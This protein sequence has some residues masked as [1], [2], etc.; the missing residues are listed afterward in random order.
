MGNQRS[1]TNHSTALANK[2]LK[3]ALII[4]LTI[5]TAEI[6][7]GIASNN[8]A[9]LGDAGHMLVDA[10]ALGMS[11]IAIRIGRRPSTSTKTYGYHRV[12]IM[13]ALA[14]GVT[15]ILVSV[16]IF[17]EA[18]QRFSNPPTVNTPLM[19]PLADNRERASRELY[20]GLARIHPVGEV[21]RLLEEL[22]LQ[23]LEHKQQVEFLYAEVAFPQTDGG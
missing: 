3:I 22:A 17:Y 6:V 7:G 16:Y 13:A 1:Q 5:M 15:L 4:V 10:L 18:Y 23:E 14:N 12:E 21:K 2:R 11:L 9:L 19:I 8:L 20:L